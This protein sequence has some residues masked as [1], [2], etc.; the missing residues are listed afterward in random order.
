MVSPLQRDTRDRAMLG[1]AESRDRCGY[2]YAR[3]LLRER[4]QK[5][6]DLEKSHH[7]KLMS[8]S[9]YLC[10]RRS[11]LQAIDQLIALLLEDRESN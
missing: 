9:D 1:R 7:Q 6:Q 10:C 3:S 11:L 2:R 5:L 4:Q 8:L